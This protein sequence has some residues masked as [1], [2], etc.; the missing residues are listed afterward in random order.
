MGIRAI[1]DDEHVGAVK[2]EHL[3]ASSW[4]SNFSQVLVID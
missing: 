2:R 4:K 3:V 1:P